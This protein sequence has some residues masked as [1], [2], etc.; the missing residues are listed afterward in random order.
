MGKGG[1]KKSIPNV[2]ELYYWGLIG[3]GR[4]V[5]F[6]RLNKMS[7]TEK[8]ICTKTGEKKRIEKKTWG[9]VKNLG[10][11]D[12]NNNTQEEKTTDT[13]RKKMD[14]LAIL[15]W[16]KRQKLGTRSRGP[17]GRKF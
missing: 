8:M 5:F 10:R 16:G 11:L 6:N 14:D 15:C 1:F 7:A 13:W 9:K 12:K 4:R 17:E 3:G 2:V